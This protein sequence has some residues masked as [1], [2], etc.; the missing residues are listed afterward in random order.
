VEF[1]SCPVL[2]TTSN[3]LHPF[4]DFGSLCFILKVP[5]PTTAMFTTS[6][7]SD[8]SGLYTSADGTS[9]DESSAVPMS[10]SSEGSQT[11]SSR[12]CAS[13]ADDRSGSYSG[14]TSGGGSSSSG[15]SSNDNRSTD[16]VSDQGDSN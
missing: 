10:S 12:S 1:S 16:G 5:G 7:S 4:A 13:F 9:T 11:S 8:M 3:V 6:I 2:C 14:S 15:Y